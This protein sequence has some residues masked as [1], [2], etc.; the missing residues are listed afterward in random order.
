MSQPKLKSSK[1][2]KVEAKKEEVKAGPVEGTEVLAPMQGTILDVKCAVN[3]PCKKGDNLVILEAMKLENEIK[4]PVDGIVKE[5]RVSK[6]Q[7]VNNK[8]VLVVIG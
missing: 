2:Q 4:A 1:V 6:G 7:T 5:V 8:D 3:K